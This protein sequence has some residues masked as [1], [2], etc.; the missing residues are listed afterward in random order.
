MKKASIPNHKYLPVRRSFTSFRLI[1]GLKKTIKTTAI[2]I[3]ASIL[4]K[5]APSMSTAILAPIIA[6]SRAEAPK[7][8]LNGKVVTPLLLNPAV[9]NAV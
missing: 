1:S 7:Y 9:A 4:L 6:P 3:T 2:I 5:T 8:A